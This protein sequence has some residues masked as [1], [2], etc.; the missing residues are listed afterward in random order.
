MSFMFPLR[1]RSAGSCGLLALALAGCSPRMR[2]ARAA[3]QT[4]MHQAALK[5]AFLGICVSRSG[6]KPVYAYHAD[7][8]FT[9]A[10]NT[11]L[12]T[13]YCALRL[14]PD[15]TLGIRFTSIRDTLFVA[16]TGDPSLL[17]PDFPQQAVL[18]FLRA[19]QG[20][21]VLCRTPGVFPVYGP[22]WAWDDYQEAFQPERDK[23]PLYGN[24]VRIRR[25][26][27]G[28][29]V[30]PRRFA[31]SVQVLAPGVPAVHRER[32]R[33][34][35][36]VSL[37][38]TAT[39][40][41]L[42]IP[43]RARSLSLQARLLAD[44]LR[45]PVSW[46]N[47]PLPGKGPFFSIA[48][49]PSDSLY[50]NMLLRS[51][52]FYAEQVLAMLSDRLLDS[53]SSTTALPLLQ[54]RMLGMLPQAPRWVDGSGL[55]RYTLLSPADLLCVL[56]SLRQRFGYVRMYALLPSGSDGTLAG[57]Y[58]ALGAQ[59]HAK[60]GS[61]SNNISLTG[62]LHTRSGKTFLFSLMA[63]HF[64]VPS[65]SVRRCFAAFLERLQRHL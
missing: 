42:Q 3:R 40:Y 20:A 61:L 34:L 56:D 22:G 1:V 52:N 57:S 33:N 48:N 7:R 5:E 59:L 43:F 11:K 13:L 50:R 17:H 27:D 25:C 47:G 45:R 64:M 44:T 37:P 54:Q 51:D 62:F 36:T 31:D 63:N 38:D 23:L 65:A 41:V 60:T 39:A 49:V 26:M 18:D 15:S 12:L 16:G 24:V 58:A 28:M 32:D 8:Y 46:K 19:H 55:S 35:F 6:R 53:I 30:L 2:I 4:L 9:P 21:I 29:Q 14:L 10:S